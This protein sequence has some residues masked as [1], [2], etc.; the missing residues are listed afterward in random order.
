MQKMHSKDY[1]H[2]HSDHYVTSLIGNCVALVIPKHFILWVQ[3]GLIFG[4]RKNL[5]I[6]FVVLYRLI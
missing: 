5:I 6:H 1:I 4:I 2:N 3:E